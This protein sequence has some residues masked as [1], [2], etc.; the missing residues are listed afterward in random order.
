MNLNWLVPNTFFLTIHGSQAYGLNHATSDLDIKGI[1]IPPANV[2]DSLFQG[3]DQAENNE[4]IH[5]LPVIQPHINPLNPKVESTVYSLRK[6]FKLAA[7]VNPNVIELLFVDYS[8]VLLERR[9]SGTRETPAFYP[10]EYLFRIRNEFLSSKAKFTFTGYAVNQLNRINR[11]RKWIINPITT[12]PT[13]ADFGLPEERPQAVEGVAREIRK[14]I[15]LWNWHQYSLDEQ[16]RSELKDCC[17]ELVSLLCNEKVVNWDNWPDE[18]WKAAILKLQAQFNL[19]EEL[20]AV[21]AREHEYK[22]ALDMYHSY[23]RW[24]ADRNPARRELEVKHGFDTKHAKHLVR[25]LRM[26]LEVLDTGMLTVTRPDAKELNHIGN[27]GWS[28]DQLITYADEMQAKIDQVYKTTKL[29]RSVN[30]E[31]LNVHYHNIIRAWEDPDRA[32]EVMEPC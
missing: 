31:K 19:S 6:F 3:F 26:G 9:T 1:C 21:V 32:G 16:Q 29:P 4:G 27:G 23:L 30:H 17:W 22:K 14:Q 24:Q 5:A 8:C 20:T 13:R 25:L 11:H 28:Y 10:F 15:E 18:H 7:D 12:K 2:R